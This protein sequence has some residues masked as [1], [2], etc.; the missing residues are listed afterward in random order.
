MPAK[1]DSTKH[2]RDR[3]LIFFPGNLFFFCVEKP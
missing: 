2:N 3:N 1:L